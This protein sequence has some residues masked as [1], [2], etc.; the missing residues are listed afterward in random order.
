MCTSRNKNL[1]R[2]ISSGAYATVFENDAFALKVLDR[3]FGDSTHTVLREGLLLQFG[4]GVALHGYLKD[5]NGL[6][7]GY[8]LERGLRS[9]SGFRPKT[10]NDI[11]VMQTWCRQILSKLASL[12]SVNIIHGDL[13]PDNILL[14]PDGSAVLCDFGLANLMTKAPGGIKSTDELYSPTYRPPEMYTTSGPWTLQAG[15]DLWAFGMTLYITLFGP[16]MWSRCGT[17]STFKLIA[18]EI[19]EN[20]DERLEKF[21]NKLKSFSSPAGAQVFAKALATCLS[22]GPSERQ[23]AWDIL[24]TIPEGKSLKTQDLPEIDLGTLE[25]IDHDFVPLGSIGHTGTSDISKDLPVIWKPMATTVAKLVLLPEGLLENYT[26]AVGSLFSILFRLNLCQTNSIRAVV[27][28]A[29]CMY[30][31]RPSSSLR[32]E[33]LSKLASTS[34]AN[35]LRQIEECLGPALL[36]PS[37]SCSLWPSTSVCIGPDF[38]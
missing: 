18:A 35:M 38:V 26:T 33:W 28:S 5:Q 30:L 29:L 14:L 23:S 1:V 3:S 32:T 2:R 10:E 37:W 17:E 16:T 21:T 20:Y 22:Y 11:M 4:Y 7:S 8:V 12:H 6:H 36:D 19:P 25:E 13:K 31:I 15:S 34:V 9:L 27:A 24:Q